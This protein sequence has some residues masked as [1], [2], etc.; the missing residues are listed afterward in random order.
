MWV[1]AKNQ[2]HPSTRANPDRHLIG[3]K[4][5]RRSTGSTGSFKRRGVRAAE[6]A[7]L[8]SVYT[9]TYRGFESLP[10]RQM[11]KAR[12]GLFH[13]ADMQ[14]GSNPRRGFDKTAGQ[15]FWTRQRPRASEGERHG[16]RESSLPLSPNKEGTVSCGLTAR[17]LEFSKIAIRRSLPQTLDIVTLWSPTDIG[18]RDFVVSWWER[19]PDCDCRD[20]R[21]SRSG[22]RSHKVGHG[23][24]G[25]AI[26]RSPTGD[27]HRWRV[28]IPPSP[29]HQE[30]VSGLLTAN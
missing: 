7:R 18:Y 29:R 21:K 11:K 16:W 17:L 4:D 26:G 24:N 13:L 30:G 1:A 27:A 22:D 14:V 8:E 10:L 15:P 9:V 3:A 28:S 23:T 12:Q 6:G 2:K 19:S 20:H 5:M 25:S